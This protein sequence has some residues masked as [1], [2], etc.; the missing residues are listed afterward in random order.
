MDSHLASRVFTVGDLVA[1]ERAFAEAARTGQARLQVSDGTELAVLPD[2]ELAALVDIVGCATQHL[3]VELV[4]RTPPAQ[5]TVADFGD[6]EW[7]AVFD[8][9]DLATFAEEL[10]AAL[11]VASR[12][13]STDELHRIVSE[14]RV[15]ADALADPERRELLLSR[16]DE[17][18]FVEVQRPG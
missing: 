10:G 13:R 1:S 4:L 16:H 17:A 9:D 8:D 3:L 12:Q 7:L 5:R 14:W 18:D 11:L 15:T 6:Q 2:H